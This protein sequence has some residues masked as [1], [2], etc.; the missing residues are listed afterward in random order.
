MIVN[1]KRILDV[2]QSILMTAAVCLC[3]MAQLTQHFND[4]TTLSLQ[5]GPVDT[6]LFKRL[7]AARA[8]ESDPAADEP[9]AL[10]EDDA[11]IYKKR[12]VELLQPRESVLSALRRLGGSAATS[13][14]AQHIS[15]RSSCTHPFLNV[16][17]SSVRL[18]CTHSIIYPPTP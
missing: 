4:C 14:S 17:H 10:D 6:A 9:L 8:G 13:P 15:M 5:D 16:H 1:K 12:I 3:R 18:E 11:A 7:A 2:K